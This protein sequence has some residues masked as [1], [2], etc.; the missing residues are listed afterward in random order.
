[1]SVEPGYGL[2]PKGIACYCANNRNHLYTKIA[3]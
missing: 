1:M 2:L 3:L